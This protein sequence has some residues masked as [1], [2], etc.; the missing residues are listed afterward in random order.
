MA[1]L[2]IRNLSKSFEGV[3]V[4]RDVTFE[5][6][7][8]QFCI[9]LGPSGCGKSTILRLIAGLESQDGGEIFIGDREVSD[10]SPKERDIAMVFQSY[11]LYPHMSVFD[12]M[13][14]SLR[15]RKTSSSLIEA[16][17][18]EAAALLGIEGLLTRRP[19][20]LSGGERQRVAIGRAIVREPKLFLFDEPLSNLDAKLRAAMRVELARLHRALGSTVVYVTHD[21]T[22]AMTLGKKIV[23]LNKGAIE[24]AGTPDEL[25]HRPESIFAASFIGSPQ[26]NLIEGTL[27]GGE[28]KMTFCTQAFAVEVN[29]QLPTGLVGQR[30][31]M[32]IRPESLRA[33]EGPI[34]GRVELVE[35]LGSEAILYVT[36]AGVKIAARVATDQGKESGE[37]VSFGIDWQGVHFFHEGRRI[38]R[39]LRPNRGSGQV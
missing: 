8:G 12:N 4:V 23:L 38:E 15:M 35:R 36:A 39:G 20:D 21:Q 3:P 30:V 34:K 22:E 7:D 25:Y 37:E 28:G 6:P 27:E 1:G 31:T 19:R 24:Q 9:L 2:S 14:F 13:A 26:I 18:R 10:L 16:K 33:G 5:V 17:V 11:A 29:E 32:T